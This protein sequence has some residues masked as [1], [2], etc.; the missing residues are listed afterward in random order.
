M[1]LEGRTALVTGAGRNLGR[2]MALQLAEQGA[3]VLVNV[4]SSRTEAEEVVDRIRRSG[5]EASVV[6][7]DVRSEADVEGLVARATEQ[8]GGI[9]VVISNAVDRLHKDF[10]E[11]TLE[12]W[13]AGQATTLDAAFLLTRAVLP[14]MVSRRWGRLLYIGGFGPVDHRVVALASAK[15]GVV[16]FCQAIARGYGP[17]GILANVLA[18][19]YMDTVRRS[20]S[21]AVPDMSAIPVRAPGAPE[22][23]AK[24]ARFLCSDENTYITGQTI[25]VNGGLFMYP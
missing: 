13:R 5:G 11:L 2:A 1:S 16:G 20:E 25:A 24:F 10:L 7:A 19:G 8:H 9:D 6:V 23:F 14:G 21:Y 18:P 22:D 12:D 17:H 4:R 15:T 3:N